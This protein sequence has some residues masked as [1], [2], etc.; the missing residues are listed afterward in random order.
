MNFLLQK[1]VLFYGV[2]LLSFI[3]FLWNYAWFCDW[4]FKDSKTR[5]LLIGDPQIQGD[6]RVLEGLHGQID[7]WYNDVYFRHITDSLLYFL[8]PSHVF[9]L[10]DLFSSQ[11]ISDEEFEHRVS[12]YRWI[13]K[14]V[15]VPFYNITGNHDIGYGGGISQHDLDRFE[16]AFG[17][18][19][20]RFVAESHLIAIVNSMNL[21]KSSYQDAFLD[22][23]NNLEAVTNES[24][25]FG[26]PV[27][28]MKHIPLHKDDFNFTGEHFKDLYTKKRVRELCAE[29][30]AS[31]TDH[32]GN[33]RWQN[34]MSPETTQRILEDVQPIFV[35]NGHDHDGCIYRHNDRTVE[36]TVRSVMGD[37][38]GYAG[39]FE[40][41]PH[42][43]AE[44]E[45]IYEYYYTPCTF[46]Y[47]STIT[48]TFA[49]S[50][51]WGFFLLVCICIRYR[52]KPYRPKQ[53]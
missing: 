2:A 11:Y 9:V 12:R 26:Y 43:I 33:I 32:A 41:Q 50:L 23:W 5:F 17:K 45:I 10:G 46:V 47:L 34:M 15:N 22:A 31:E 4:H 29:R 30:A 13:Y 37:F 28:I 51:V 16:A 52:R 7:V 8:Q 40:I 1:F 20:T 36:F 19:N 39:L 3:F 21:D 14:N 6:L 35:F 38:G 27:I 24:K 53:Q 44:K 42:R 49:L 25:T 18:V 48:I